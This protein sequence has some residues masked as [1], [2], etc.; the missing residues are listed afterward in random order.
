MPK[1]IRDARRRRDEQ[2]SRC[3]CRCSGSSFVC[4]YI[5]GPLLA[6]AVALTPDYEGPWGKG[7]V[8]SEAASDVKDFTAGGHPAG[9][10]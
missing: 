5:G 8:G 9:L 1:G 4:L 10:D 7:T 2:V 3:R 6:S